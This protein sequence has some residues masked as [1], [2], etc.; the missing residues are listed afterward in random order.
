MMPTEWEW[1]S[2]LM[3]RDVAVAQFHDGELIEEFNKNSEN[4]YVVRKKFMI[5]DSDDCGSVFPWF[6]SSSSMFF[7]L[8]HIV[9]LELHP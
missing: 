4:I 7:R 2:N 9:I 8:D 1:S 3:M 5:S 6:F